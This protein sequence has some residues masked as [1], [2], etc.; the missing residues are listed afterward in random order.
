M[1]LSSEIQSET[2]PA[3][4]TITFRSILLGLVTIAVATWYMSYFAGNLVKSYLPVAALIPFVMWVGINVGL[5]HF[6]PRFALS[7]IELLTIF[8]MMWIVGSLPAVGWGFYAVSLIPSPEF[9]A[10]P[11]NRL[12]DAVIPFLP[13]WFFLDANIPDVRAVYTG[14]HRGDPVPWLL[15]VRPFF[16]WFVGCISAVMAGFFGS[17]LFFKQWQEKERLVFPM[18]EFPVA[19]IE[20]ADE[21]RV[22]VVLRDKFSGSGS[23]VWPV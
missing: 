13:G 14:R 16:W 19:L 18:S 7:R 10:S 20:G 22:P 9:F 17:V 2:A 4:D 8:S 1:A 15:W 3:P 11:E 5:I 21:G 12:R 23:G 6:A